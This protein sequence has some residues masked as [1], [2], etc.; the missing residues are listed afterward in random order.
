VVVYIGNVSMSRLTVCTLVLTALILTGCTSSARLHNLDTGEVIPIKLKNYGIGQGE[1][2][3]K[4]PNGKEVIG[5]HVLVSGGVTNWATHD[6][7]MDSGGCEWAKS[8]G[9]SFDQPNTKYGYAV[10]VADGVLIKLMYAIKRRTSHGCGI[11]NSG[12]K[13]HLIF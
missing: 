9:F 1:I 3:G 2:T 6:C 10:L 11:D 13:Y 4:L 12:R 5:A 8:L 7:Q